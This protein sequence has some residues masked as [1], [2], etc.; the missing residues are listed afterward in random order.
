MERFPYGTRGNDYRPRSLV[1]N[2]VLS[3]A[4]ATSR[5]IQI[6]VTHL[7]FG[8]TAG[9]VIESF[10]PAYSASTSDVMIMFEALVQIAL[11]GVLVSQVGAQLNDNDPTF[12]M[13]FSLGLFEAQPHLRQRIDFLAASAKKKVDLYVRK[14]APQIATADNP[15]Q[16]SRPLQPTYHQASSI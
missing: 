12:G 16:D 15:N 10:M 2:V 6:S 1:S 9:A 8:I 4:M 11:N 14:M 5:A 3:S 7:A 13:P